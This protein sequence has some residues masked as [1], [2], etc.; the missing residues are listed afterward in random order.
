M[1]SSVS[2]DPVGM[3]DGLTPELHRVRTL[4]GSSNSMTFH[5]FP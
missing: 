5:D 2:D 3:R 1:M 4:F